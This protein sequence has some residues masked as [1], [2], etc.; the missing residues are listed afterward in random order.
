MALA[1][2]RRRA[3]DAPYWPGFVDAMAAAG[4]VIRPEYVHH[5]AQDADEALVIARGLLGL[6]ERPTAIFSAQNLITMGTVRALREQDLQWVVALVGYD[7]FALADLLEPAV[8]VIA[9]D[10][11]AI[12]HLAADLLFRRMSN[13]SE[14]TRTHVV[15]S[16]LVTRGSG[17]ILPA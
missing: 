7:D 13:S 9:Q 6:S 5:G 12:G 11:R 1:S 3:E 15:P 2:R 14:P 16:R 8:T 17:E 10:A 4:A